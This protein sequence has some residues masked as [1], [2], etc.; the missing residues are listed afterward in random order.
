MKEYH[1]GSHVLVRV[2]P[3]LPVMVVEILHIWRE[4]KKALG[5]TGGSVRLKLY[6]R[7]EDTSSGRN[8]HHGKVFTVPPVFCLV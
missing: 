4:T 7:P 5:E 8:H 6:S 3:D 2:M 1:R